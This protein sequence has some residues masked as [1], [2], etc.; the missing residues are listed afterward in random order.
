MSAGSGTQTTNGSATGYRLLS[1]FGKLFY[2][3][4]DRYLASVTVRRDGSS[5]FGANNQY[6]VFPAFTL[7][8]RINNEDFFKNVKNVS[9]LKLRAGIGTVG[10]Q[11]ALSNTGP[12]TLFQPNYG[13]ASPTY[14]QWLNIGTA[15]DLGGVNT[16]TLPSGFVQV[17]EGNPDLKWESSTETNLGLDFGFLNETITGSFDYFIK[18]TKDILIPPP[19]PGVLGEGQNTV[20]NGAN[21]DDWGWEAL[22]SY[23]HRTKSGLNF[24]IT[25][26]ASHFQNKITSIPDSY[27]SYFVGDANHSIVGRSPQSIFGYETNGIFQTSKEAQDA[28][29]QPGVTDGALQGAGRLRYVDLNG[30]D[31]IDV[32]DQTWL[33][34]TLPKLEYGIRI[35]LDYKNWDFSIFG[36]GVAGKTGFDPTNSLMILLTRE[37]ISGQVL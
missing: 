26:N 15:Y 28:P 13:T 8:W 34:T 29:F 9:N 3:Y 31:T 21:M 30:N 17:Q 23:N 25:A 1:Q 19:I 10:N 27:R 4:S 33:G 35:D 20:V 11:Q 16:G 32:N 2:S 18:K 24:N 22:L 14:P 36:S 12:L 7:G 6:G 37:T 5:R